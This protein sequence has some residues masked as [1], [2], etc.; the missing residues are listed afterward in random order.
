MLTSFTKISKHPFSPAFRKINY[1]FDNL[2]CSE[3]LE[4]TY[5]A[6]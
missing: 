2:F 6:G 4:I 3:L 1:G 5:N